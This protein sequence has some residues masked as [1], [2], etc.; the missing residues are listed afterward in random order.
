K[1]RLGRGGEVPASLVGADAKTD[2]AV[3]QVGVPLPVAAEWGD[4]DQLDVG[5]W[6]LAIGSPFE[7]DRTV[8]A[9]IVSATGRSN[10]RVVGETAYED[11]IQTDAAINPGNSGG[12]LINLRGQVVGINTAI[13]APQEGG[14]NIGIG[15]AISSALAQRAVEG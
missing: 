6:V 9:G 13:Y 12:P 4:S 2:L 3:L 1:V 8:T 11:F 14:S 10:L 5:D 15:F 7:L